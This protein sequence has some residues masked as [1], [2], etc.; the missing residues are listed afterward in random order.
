MSKITI[1]VAMS[2]GAF[3]IW[4]AKSSVVPS[5]GV[6]AMMTILNEDVVAGQIL[7]AIER[8]RATLVLPPFARVLPLVRLLPVRAFDR[9]ADFF[10]VN[11]TMEHFRG[12][13]SPS[14]GTG[15]FGG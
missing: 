13:R 11:R 2:S 8:G 1:I 12:R 3:D 9:V 15:E 6:S 5:D 7:D 4:R 10:G 14:R